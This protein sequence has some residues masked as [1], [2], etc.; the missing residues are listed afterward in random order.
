MKKSTFILVLLM[1]FAPLLVNA[2][3][4]N[5]EL[6]LQVGAGFFMGNS[7]PA[8]GYTRTHEFAWMRDSENM[9]AFETFGHNVRLAEFTFYDEFAVFNRILGNLVVVKT[10]VFT[11]TR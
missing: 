5:V 8:A 4:Q 7:N 6:G 9:P 10:S 1:A 11:F 2:Q 3:T